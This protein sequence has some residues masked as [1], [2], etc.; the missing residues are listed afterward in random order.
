ME[1]TVTQLLEIDEQA[2]TSKAHSAAAGAPIPAAIPIP[3][4]V[5]ITYA[6]SHTRAAPKAVTDTL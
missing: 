6:T 2:R 4:A 1:D 3:R 5:P